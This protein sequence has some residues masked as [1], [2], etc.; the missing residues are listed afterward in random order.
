M[1][2]NNAIIDS[3]Q[4]I[5]EVQ[6]VEA[7]YG[8]IRNT[9]NDAMKLIWKIT[10]VSILPSN[11]RN[12]S[13]LRIVHLIKYGYPV[14]QIARFA[15]ITAAKVHN[16]AAKYHLTIKRR[17][18]A[19]IKNYDIYAP[20]FSEIFRY[21][22]V[23]NKKQLKKHYGFEVIKCNKVFHTLPINSTYIV[24]WKAYKKKDDMHYLI[25]EVENEFPRN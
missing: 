5:H 6:K 24:S 17:F 20:S 9:P 15:N 23:S 3:T 13:D 25:N 4:L 14:C 16:I 8:S 10:G 22:N 7:T 11:K 12:N 19:K 1:I 18:R 21:F 2:K